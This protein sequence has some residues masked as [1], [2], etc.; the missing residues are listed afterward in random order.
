MGDPKK[1]HKKYQTASHP[2]I[3]A[4]IEE[5]RILRKEFGLSTRKE[6]LIAQSFLKKYKAIAKTLIATKSAQTLKEKEQVLTKLQKLGLLQTGASLDQIFSLSIRDIL[7]R[8]I[9]SLLVH[10]SLARSM[11]QARQFVVHRHILIG[12][13][14]I[15][16]PSY[17]MP[18]SEEV[19]LT[20]K[21]K[22]TLASENHPERI[23]VA[24]TIH[25][26]AE[27]IKQKPSKKKT[28]EVAVPEELN[29]ESP[30]Q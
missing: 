28:D 21:P 24:K 20:F 6:I 22:S 8:R 23:N 5:Q 4:D 11:K 3:R 17:L 7:N 27:A 9:Q 14:E 1:V 26:E 18:V 16:S 12:T 25:E 30:A 10:K 19:L 29:N 15:T 2:W 13:K